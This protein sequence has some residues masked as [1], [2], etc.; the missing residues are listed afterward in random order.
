MDP[1]ALKPLPRLDPATLLRTYGLKPRQGL[2]QNFLADDAALRQIVAAAE[3]APDDTVLEIGP[4]LGHLTRY[5]AACARRVLAVEIDSSMLPPLR[6]NLTACPNVSILQ[7]DILKLDLAQLGLPSG[8]LVVANIPYY[9]TGELI[10]FL[11][12]APFKPARLVLT[13]QKEVA[14]AICAT[15]GDLSIRALGVQ[16]Y[17]RPT[18]AAQIP[19][20]AFYPPPAV[21]S[22]VLR[23][24]LYPQP[25]IRLERL[26]AFFT[27]VKAGFS[28]KRKTLRNSLAGGLGCKPEKAVALLQAAGIDPQR[29]AE[30]LSIAE[31]DGLVEE[32]QATKS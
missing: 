22:A 29:R 31:W 10:P 7:A 3:I 9:I 27:L 2:G 21:D 24:E 16:V 26:P 32:Y 5:L 30:T 18:I 11:M 8:Y 14:G 28:Q 23:I 20:A 1:G 19:A 12:E 4:G 25:L 6:Q 15:P 13:I 17:G